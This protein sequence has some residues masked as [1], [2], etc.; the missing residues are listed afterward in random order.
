MVKNETVG[1]NE[2]LGLFVEAVEEGTTSSVFTSGTTKFRRWPE[3]QIN[4]ILPTAYRNG[5]PVV[6]HVVYKNS[7]NKTDDE[8]EVIVNEILDICYDGWEPILDNQIDVM[9]I[10]VKPGI[11]TYDLTI[12]PLDLENQIRVTVRRVRRANDLREDLLPQTGDSRFEL[13]WLPRSRPLL[14]LR[15]TKRLNLWDNKKG[16]AIQVVVMNRT[17]ITC[18]GSVQ[19]QV[20]SNKALSNNATLTLQ[21]LSRGRLITQTLKLEADYSCM[22]RKNGFEHYDCNEGNKI[23]CLEGWMGANC[24]SPFYD[25]NGCEIGGI[26]LGSDR[27]LRMPIGKSAPLGTKLSLERRRNVG[28]TPRKTFFKHKVTLNLDGNFG[29]EFRAVAYVFR[30]NQMASDYIKIGGL[31]SCSSPVMAETEHG[32]DFQFDKQFVVPGENVSIF[33][34]LPPGREGNDDAANT[35]LLSMTDVSSKQFDSENFRLIDFD[36]F[37]GLLTSNQMHKREF[38]VQGTEDAYQAAGMDFILVSPKSKMYTPRYC[39]SMIYFTNAPSRMPLMGPIGPM[40]PLAA[41]RFDFVKGDISHHRKKSLIRIPRVRDFFPEVWLFETAK[42]TNGNL[43][44]SLIVPDTLTTWEANAVCF[45][46]KR[47]LWMPL[48]KSQ[49]TVRMPFFVEFAPPLMARRGEVLHLP[50]SVFVYPETT[51]N[52]ATITMTDTTKADHEP[53]VGVYGGVGGK[54]VQ[55]TCYEVEMSVETN[56]QD[57]QVVGATAFTTCIC[58]GDLK[59]TFYLPLRPLRVGHLNVTAKAVAKR[60]SWVCGDND[61]GFGIWEQTREAFTVTDAVQRS[62]RVIAEGVERSIT[63]GGAF[64]TSKG[65]SK[66]EQEMT[67]SLPDKQIVGGSLRSY[68]TVSGNVVGRALANLDSLIQMPTGCGEQ[69]LV[70]VAPSVYVLRHLLLNRQGNTSSK[71]LNSRY[72]RLIRKAAAY[73]LSGFKNQ[74]NYL[75]PNNGAFSVFGPQYSANGSTWLTAYVFEVFSE[76]EKLPI[77]SITG[78]QLDAC[79]TLSSAF[80]FLLSQQR[81]SGDGCFEEASPRFLP[82]VQ[83]SN[84]VENRLQLTAHVLAALGSAS[85]TLRETKGGDFRSCVRSA[86]R[87]IESTAQ[88]QPFFKWSTLLLAK[89]IHATK[90]FRREASSSMREA[91]VIELMRRSKLESTISG[92]LRWWPESA[93]TMATGSYLTKVLDLE[94]TAYALL[95]LSPI[96]LSQEDQLATMKWV[97]KRQNENGGFYSTKD[98]VV[99]LRALTQNADTFPSPTQATPIVIHSKPKSLVNQRL[100]VGKENQLIAHIFEIGAHDQIDISS[101]QISIESLKRVCVSTYFT[102]IYNVPKPQSTNY[103]FKLEI[104]VNQGVSNATVA[105]T[106]ALTTLCLRHARAQATGM[107]LVTLQLPSG[108]TVKMSQLNE[109][110]LNAELRRLEFNVKKQEVSAYFNGFSIKGSDAEKCFTVPLHQRTFVQEASPGLVTARDYYS[111]QETVEAP[112]HLDSCQLYWEQ[113]RGEIIIGSSTHYFTASNTTTT[114][115]LPITGLKPMCPKCEE[116]NHTVLLD[117]LNRSLCLHDRPLYIFKIYDTTN[118]TAVPGLLYSFGYGNHSTSWNTTINLLKNCECKIVVK[119]A[120]ALFGRY[121]QPGSLNVD[122]TGREVVIFEDLVKL[123]PKFKDM[124]AAQMKGLSKNER[125]SWCASRVP[126]FAVLQKL[127]NR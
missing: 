15:A 20:Q 76:A 89:V 109:V 94:T 59:K 85:T 34:K 31:R 47:G 88:H 21:Y 62:V 19:L 92:S 71:A 123:V 78:Q 122:L 22:P 49:L 67:I 61:D 119:E 83:S 69:N 23:Y 30:G 54:G 7:V 77:I 121:I 84:K 25:D 4:L 2:R 8:L 103:V 81:A 11:E 5:L 68:I 29:P 58:M 14:D 93:S 126:F 52:P 32:G 57:W 63:L 16:F 96:D 39:S 37:A 105:C 91:M 101:L 65:F 64:C 44:K 17:S 12:P 6:G 18:P 73:I 41:Y 28:I 108:W 106:T 35:C 46:A 27:C 99:A 55:R 111:P 60:G 40:G 124:L 42:L 125:K 45:T 24:Q 100:E 118:R 75:H 114:T 82:W 72:D 70:K 36:T 50:I 95:A 97:L 48:K 115:A 43:N 102:A 86:I 110:P 113:P 98:T 127:A 33:L 1:W 79:T 120:F 9:K 90:A 53:G 66:K 116:M 13:W 51:T 38:E 87:C 10:P 104:S 74:L 80:D 26:S 107:L 117:Y 56:L 112:L 3:P